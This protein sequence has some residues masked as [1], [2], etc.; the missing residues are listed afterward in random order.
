MTVGFLPLAISAQYL[1]QSLVCAFEGKY[2]GSEDPWNFATDEYEQARY[3]AIV[4]S[5]E[6]RRSGTRGNRLFLSEC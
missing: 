1:P 3:D 6:H 5:L 2:K 4:A